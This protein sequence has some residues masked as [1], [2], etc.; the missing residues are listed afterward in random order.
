MKLKF[1]AFLLLFFAAFENVSAG[2]IN[3]TLVHGGQTRKYV[4]YVPAIYTTQGIKVPLLVGLHGNGDNAANFSQ[5]CMSSISDTANYIVVYP[6]ALP[7]PILTTNAWHSGAGFTGYEVNS[8]VDDVGFINKL[9][10]TVIA[11]YQIDT[12][13]MYVFGF[14]FGG[15]MTNKMAASTAT[16]WAAAVGATECIVLILLFDTVL[17][18]SI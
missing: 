17:R 12:N 10:N 8:A 18:A 3:G 11:S 16:R 6:E 4:I 1:Y 14:S 2:Y 9:M 15:F 5:I 13:R 7:D